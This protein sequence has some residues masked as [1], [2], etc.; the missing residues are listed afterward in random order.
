[1]TNGTKLNLAKVTSYGRMLNSE[2]GL[3]VMGEVDPTN[4]K[5]FLPVQEGII[6]TFQVHVRGPIEL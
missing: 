6:F 2:I 4:Q 5:V 1:M 3:P